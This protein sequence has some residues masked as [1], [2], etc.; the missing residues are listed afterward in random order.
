MPVTYESIATTTLGASAASVTFSSIPATYTDLILQ[1]AFS[2]TTANF[3]VRFQFNT[4]TGS[5][6]SYTYLLGTGSSPGSG[7]ASNSTFIGTYFSVG[8]STNPQPLTMQ[9]QNY[10]NTVT[11][12]TSLIRIGASDKELNGIVALWRDTGAINS[13]TIFLNLTGQ[14]AADSTFTL[15]GI[16]A[17]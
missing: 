4:D 3:D 16:K 17:A 2:T 13:I 15:Y 9:I 7:R 11:N 5:N 6:Y 14:Y 8:T 10:S 12:K 1:G